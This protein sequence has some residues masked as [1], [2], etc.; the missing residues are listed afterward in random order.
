MTMMN[1]MT[2]LVEIAYRSEDPGII[3]YN[4]D[5]KSERDKI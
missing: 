2:I 3:K 1:I 5:H 4:K